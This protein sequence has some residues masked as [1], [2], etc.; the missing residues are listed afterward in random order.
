MLSAGPIVCQNV[1]STATITLPCLYTQTHAQSTSLPH[2]L[3]KPCTRALPFHCPA[4]SFPSFRVLHF[5]PYAMPTPAETRAAPPTASLSK[6]Q[7]EHDDDDENHDDLEGGDPCVA[8]TNTNNNSSS[9]PPPAPASEDLA[10]TID[11]NGVRR[12]FDAQR[13]R[14][15]SLQRRLAGLNGLQQRLS[16]EH[17]QLEAAYQTAQDDLD[18]A[19]E[20]VR[21]LQGLEKGLEKRFERLVET[22]QA[23][24]EAD[25]ARHVALSAELKITVEEIQR[26]Q[27]RVHEEAAILRAKREALQAQL[28]VEFASIDKEKSVKEEREKALEAEM[29]GYKGK[30]VELEGAFAAIDAEVREYKEV[31]QS[32]DERKARTTE[33]LEK[34]NAGIDELLGKA[35]GAFAGGEGEV[36][37]GDGGGGDGKGEGEEGGEK[38]RA[39]TKEKLLRLQKEVKVRRRSRRVAWCV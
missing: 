36:E 12:L 19:E 11:P 38:K 3:A 29:A 14:G 27:R 22:R 23:Q 30:I 16:A 17:T 25:A 15:N 39:V 8:S 2:R 21:R 24:A 5:V 10:S 31:M 28:R 9:A 18:A 37:G 33:M 32:Y 13:K 4:T 35:K 1:S 20:T 34:T 7:L 26:E 6:L